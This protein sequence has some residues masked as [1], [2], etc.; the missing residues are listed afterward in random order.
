MVSNDGSYGEF[1]ALGLPIFGDYDDYGGIENYIKDENFH[2]IKNLIEK[3]SYSFEE[4]MRDLYC[5]EAPLLNSRNERRILLKTMLEKKD[6][7][8]K[9]HDKYFTQYK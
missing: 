4:F 5:S 1:F 8:Q 9:T 2:V 6:I 3:N 7:N